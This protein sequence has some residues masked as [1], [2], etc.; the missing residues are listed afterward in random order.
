MILDFSKFIAALEANTKAML[1]HA[2]ALAAHA[3]GA[4]EGAV[5]PKTRGRKAVGEVNGVA[6]TPEQLAANIAASTPAAAAVTTVAPVIVAPVTPAAVSAELPPVAVQITLQQVADAI[7]S[8]ANS[9]D[10]GR[11]K[12]VS[13]LTQFGVKKVPELKA[14]Q[15]AAVLEAVKAKATAPVSASAGLV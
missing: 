1:V 9:A 11:D 6:L 10:G 8:L 5:A 13:I 2:E 12:A 3:V 14:E 4:I 15:Y 7:I